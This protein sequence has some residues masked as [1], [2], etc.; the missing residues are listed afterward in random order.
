MPSQPLA[1]CRHG[2]FTL[3]K[4]GVALEWCFVLVRTSHMLQKGMEQIFHEWLCTPCS[5][6][7]S[8]FADALHRQP[9]VAGLNWLNHSIAEPLNDSTAGFADHMKS[10]KLPSVYWSALVKWR[11]WPFYGTHICYRPKLILN[12]ALSK[13]RACWANIL[14]TTGQYF[15]QFKS[16][17]CGVVEIVERSL[18]QFRKPKSNKN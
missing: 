15:F 2:R 17:V 13:T 5:I 12:L 6:S 1:V 16:W 11:I 14:Q 4:R 7:W 8:C 3:M 10:W 9:Y 18:A